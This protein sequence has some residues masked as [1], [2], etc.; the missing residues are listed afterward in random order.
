MLANKGGQSREISLYVMGTWYKLQSTKI[1]KEIRWLSVAKAIP[2]EGH[3]EAWWKDNPPL[4]PEVHTQARGR[5]ESLGTEGGLWNGSLSSGDR[6]K[7]RTPLRS[8]DFRPVLGRGRFAYQRSSFIEIR[9]IPTH[10]NLRLLHLPLDTHATPEVTWYETPYH[11]LSDG[12][13]SG[14]GPRP[15]MSVTNFLSSL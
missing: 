5:P 11:W 15:H 1:P 7:D 9:I 2:T 4:K 3:P 13:P 10:R 8:L 12:K 6:L 14:L